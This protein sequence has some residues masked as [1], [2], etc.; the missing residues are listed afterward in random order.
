MR[1]RTIVREGETVAM[2]SARTGVPACMLMR[3]SGIFSPAWLTPGREI[4]VPEPDFCRNFP[5]QICPVRA[6][7]L[8]AW[9]A[10]DECIEPAAPETAREAAGKSGLPPRLHLIARAQ[11]LRLPHGCRAVAVHYGETWESLAEK[12][13][14]EPEALMRLNRLWSPLLPGVRIVAR[15][16]GPI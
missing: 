11:S 6:C 5:A 16:D 7:A 2:L 12:T 15:S 8:P 3:A 14:A 13:H 4:D 9:G 1:M 10:K